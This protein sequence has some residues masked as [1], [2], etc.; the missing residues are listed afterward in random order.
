MSNLVAVVMAAGKGTRMKSKLPKVM[1]LLAGKTLIEHV[2]DTVSHAGIKRQMVV[3]GH[4]REGIEACIQQRAEIVVQEEQLGTGHAVMQ[5]IPFLQDAQTVLVLSG[6]Q[7]LLKSETLLA[8]IEMHETQGASA[9][10]LTA[11]M[12]Q[13][14]GYGR[15]LKSSDNLVKIIE[16]KDATSTEREIREINTGAYCFKGSALINALTKITTQNAQG[17]YYLTEV[18]EVFSKLKEKMLTYCTPDSQEALGINS[19]G[20]LAEAEAILRKNI[21]EHWM[22]EGVTL[23]DP[24]STFI[25]AEVELAKDVTILPF[26]RLIGKTR[27][28]EDAVI[29]PQTSLHNCTVGRGAEVVYTVAKDAV[30]GDNCRIGPFTYLRPGTNLGAEVKI[31]DFVEIKNSW[32]GTGAKVPHLSYIGDAHIGKSANIGAG[33]ITCNYDGVHKHTTKIGDYAFIGSNTNLVAPI[34]V[35]E[36]A[37]TGAGSTITKNVPAKAL[38]VE[39]S[40]QLIKEHWHREKMK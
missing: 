8:L 28:E 38:A 17:E 1:H 31:G 6:D 11:Y 21:L 29:G 37:V 34:E 32:I 33:T 3:V 4:G 14:F 35:G 39:R 12:D 18:F 36:H 10:V 2:L 16:E 26:T 30:I 25:D 22:A 13:P 7:P 5:A 15:I 20:Q 24:A 23:I 19:R 27:I 9:T 40:H